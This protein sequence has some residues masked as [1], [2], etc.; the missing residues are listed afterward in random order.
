MIGADEQDRVCA[1]LVVRRCVMVENVLLVVRA[2]HQL[3]DL[4]H[5]LPD[6]GYVQWPE[7]LVEGLVCEVLHYRK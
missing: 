1:L 7:V 5:I 3:L 4:V 6:L 2:P